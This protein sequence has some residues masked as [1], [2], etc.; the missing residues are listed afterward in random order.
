MYVAYVCECVCVDEDIRV[1]LCT[2]ASYVDDCV[3]VCCMQANMLSQTSACAR[4][5]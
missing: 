2:C 4:R 3:C 5:I 1:K